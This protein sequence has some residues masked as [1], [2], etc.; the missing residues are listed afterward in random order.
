MSFT[1]R[2]HHRSDL[3]GYAIVPLATPF[4]A[5]GTLDEAA[6]GRLVDY[7][8]AGGCQGI[9]VGGTTGEAASMSLSARLALTAA[10]VRGAAGRAAIFAGIGDNCVDHSLALARDAFR[11]GADAVVA[12]LPS[13]YPLSP[14]DIE[15]YFLNLADH[16]DGPLYLYNI[17][18]TTRHSVPLDVLQ[19]L[20][21]HPRIAGVKDSE[22]DGARQEKVAAEFAGRDDF[23]VFCGSVAFT[24]AAMRA[25]AD[26]FV[27]SVGNLAPRLC[28][29]LMDRWLARDEAGAKEVQA[30]LGAISAVYQQGRNLGESLAAL[31]GGFEA[32]GLASRHMLP[33]L[34]PVQ[35]QDVDRIRRQLQD[36]HFLS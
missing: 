34:R 8:I 29:D 33:P 31:K 1:T 15:T 9:L 18:Q 5:D 6:V 28:R 11:V 35:Q 19:R 21:A 10:A 30:K 12:H 2:L 3:R 17:P 32:L 26:G 14:V 7:T 16:S 36:L 25:G 24:G 22:P 20:S 4:R 13:Y 27:P 23:S